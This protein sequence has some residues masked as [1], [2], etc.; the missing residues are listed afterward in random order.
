[1]QKN[2]INDISLLFD[3]NPIG[4]SYL[5]LFYKLNINNEIIYVGNN[6][7]FQEAYCKIFYKLNLSK[8]LKYLKSKIIIELLRNIEEYFKLDKNFL[9]EMY[10]FDYLLEFKNLS[11]LKNPNINHKDNINLLKNNRNDNFLN[12]GRKIFKEIFESGKKFYHIHPG[13]MY[14][15]RG[16][17]GSLNSIRYN[18]KLGR[19]L[20]L[21]NK[22]IDNGKIIFREEIDYKK[23]YFP[24]FQ[25]FKIKE[26][27]DIWYSFIDPA[28]RVSLL[29]KLIN[30]KIN[31]SNFCTINTNEKNNYFS[32]L[33]SDDLSKL[34]NNSVFRNE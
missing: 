28:I 14:K 30:E 21:M 8:P 18:N 25:N 5:Y 17:D 26:L 31:L 1:M 19:T 34:F 7:Y 20:F 33:K 9:S 10:K 2:I 16:A 13:Y 24:L 12:T 6:F 27:Y 15:V 32:F 11:F 23:I 3:E 29:K 4:R 22:K